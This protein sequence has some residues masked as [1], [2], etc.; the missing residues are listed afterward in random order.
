MVKSFIRAQEAFDYYYNALNEIKSGVNGTSRFKNVG[1]YIRYPEAN[2]ID[3]PYRNWSESYAKREFLWYM[4]GNRSVKELK[5]FAPIWDK[6]HNGDDLVNSNY[7]NLWQE[8]QQLEKCIEQIKAE[9]VSGKGGRQIWLTLFDGKRKDQYEFDTPCT[10]NIGFEVENGE[11]NMRVLM[12][13]NDIWYG[14]CND[15]YCFSMLMKIVAVRTNLVVGSYFHYAAD[16]H[17][18]EANRRK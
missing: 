12:R 14:F 11:L 10:L 2:L 15:Q 6:M 1:F 3:L 18:Y 7:G 17:L 8:N 5:K 9:G 13:S 4:S 16:L